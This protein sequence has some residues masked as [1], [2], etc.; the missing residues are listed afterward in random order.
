MTGIVV[1]ARLGSTRLPGKALL[2]LGE[3]DEVDR[4][5]EREAHLAEA[6]DALHMGL[7]GDLATHEDVVVIAGDAEGDLAVGAPKV[8]RQPGEGVGEEGRAEGLLE[9]QASLGDIPDFDVHGRPPVLERTGTIGGAGRLS[10][11]SCPGSPP[12]RFSPP[13]VLR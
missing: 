2:P 9:L 6:A 11:G 1:Q 10:T 8:R 7:A 4:G 5:L 3:V 13:R 12:G